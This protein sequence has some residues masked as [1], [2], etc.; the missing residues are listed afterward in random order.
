MEVSAGAHVWSTPSG[1]SMNTLWREMR[2]LVPY[3]FIDTLALG[4]T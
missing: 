2:L 3:S 1:L 4:A